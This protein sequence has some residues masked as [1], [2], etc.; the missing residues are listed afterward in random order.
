MPYPP[1]ILDHHLLLPYR[2]PPGLPPPALP[3]FPWPQ[4]PTIGTECTDSVNRL[5]SKH[6]PDEPEVLLDKILELSNDHIVFYMGV[7]IYTGEYMTFTL[8]PDPFRPNPVCVATVPTG[9]HDGIGWLHGGAWPK[10]WH[11]LRRPRG[12][13]H[14]RE[15][16][17]DG[18]GAALGRYGLG[19]WALGRRRQQSGF[20]GRHQR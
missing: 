7:K 16:E 18:D 8:I 13:R 2:T 20:I 1:N 15:D 11:P 10:R 19:V 5:K 9:V 6:E 4:D 3:C 14:R 17:T 12:V